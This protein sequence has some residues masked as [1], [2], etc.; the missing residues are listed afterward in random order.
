MPITFT[1]RPTAESDD[2]FFLGTIYISTFGYIMFGIDTASTVKNAWVR[3]DNVNIPRGA[4]IVSAKLSGTAWQPDTDLY[5]INVYMNDADDAV[6]P[7]DYTD[8]AGKAKTTAFSNWNATIA[9]DTVTTYE[10]PDFS[11]A[12][13]EVINRAGWA[14]GNAMMVFLENNVGFDDVRTFLS[15]ESGATLSALF[16]VNYRL[17]GSVRMFG[18][19]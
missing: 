14:S 4:Q 17:G 16:T 6:A 9:W 3:V 19:K 18:V 11:E 5:D 15:L 13:Q 1:G 8:Y 12:V 2:G 7:T 10:T